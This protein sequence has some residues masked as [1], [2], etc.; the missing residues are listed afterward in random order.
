[1]ITYILAATAAMMAFL[2]WRIGQQII[3]TYQHIDEDT[4]RN[5]W[6]GRL[7]H[8]TNEYRRVI[9]HLGHCEQCQALFEQIRQGKPL[10]DHLIT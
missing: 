1:M 10:E 4:M 2:V 6:R 3:Q 9:T 5:F 8:G 7:P